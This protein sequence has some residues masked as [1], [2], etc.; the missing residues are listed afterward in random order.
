M[1]SY[2]KLLT[3]TNYNQPTTWSCLVGWFWI[4]SWH[5]ALNTSL[6]GLNAVVSQLYSH[7]KPFGTKL[8]L[9]QRHLSE[10]QPNTTH[11]PSLQEIMTSFPQT[12]ISTE[13]RRYV[14]DISS[15]AEKFQHRFRDFAA[16]RRSCFFPLLCP[17][18]LMTPSIAVG[19]HVVYPG[20]WFKI[21]NASIF[22]FDIWFK[23][24]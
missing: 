16:V 15:L 11:F 2:S 20:C 12:N 14:A 4:F 10:T 21:E 6:Q 24:K 5:N 1:S 23:I 9:F 8:L 7:I 18:T 13:M 17:W 19:I 3:N 22:V